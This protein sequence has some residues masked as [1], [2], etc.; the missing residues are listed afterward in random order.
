MSRIKISIGL[1]V[2]AI[3]SYIAGRWHTVSS[4]PVVKVEPQEE[5]VVIQ[6]QDLV[7]DELIFEVFGPLRILLNENMIEKEGVIKLPLGQFADSEDL[8]FKQFKYTGNTKTMKFYPSDSYP[9]RGTRVGHRRFFQSIQ[10]AKDAGFIATKL[11][12]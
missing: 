12:K 6:M 3:A 2:I 8:Q 7:G 10:A 4:A 5:I 9:A 1:L 11:I